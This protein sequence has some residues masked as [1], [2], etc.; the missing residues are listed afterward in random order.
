MKD[1]SAPEKIFNWLDSPLSVARFYGG[2]TYKGCTYNIDYEGEGQ[3]LVRAD[4]LKKVAKIRKHQ[5]AIPKF[6]QE[7]LI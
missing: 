7:K 3:P 5:S 4:I 1:N 6:Q 2:C